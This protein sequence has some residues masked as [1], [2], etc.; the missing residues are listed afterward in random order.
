[1]SDYEN[2]APDGETQHHEPWN[3][4][5]KI[6]RAALGSLA[7]LVVLAGQ[8]AFSVYPDNWSWGLALS[9][10]G[11][12]FFM[13]ARFGRQFAWG[14]RLVGKTPLS[15]SGL[16]VVIAAVFSIM[17]IWVDLALEETPRSNFAPVVVLWAA[18]GMALLAS[19]SQGR[20]WFGGGREWLRHNRRE[21]VLVALITF[22][23]AVVRFYQ[24]GEIPRVINGDEGII[25]QAAL[26]SSQKPLANP[27]SMWE[28]I[29]G[30]FLQGIAFSMRIFGRNPFGLRLLPAIGGTLAIP[31]IYILGRRLFGPRVAFL[32]AV[33]LAFSHSHIHFSR[34]V[35]VSY[36]QGTL[37]EPLMLYFLFSGLEERSSLRM[38]LAA[39]LLSIHFSIYVDSVIFLVLAFIFML[40][41]WFV[42]PPL[43]K[44]RSRQVI[45]F[46]VAAAIMLLP[47]A[48]Y[49]LTHMQEFMG[50]FNAD[51]VI[52]SGWL[53]DTMA[54][55]GQSAVVILAQRIVHAFLSMSYYAAGDFYGATIPLL[56][57]V[58]GAFFLIG[59][60]YSL[61]R[62]REPR[63]LLLNGYMWAPAVA[64]GLTAIPPEADSYRMLIALPAAILLAAVGLEELLGVLSLSNSVGWKARAA[65]AGLI[66]VSAAILNLKSYFVDFAL[67]CRYGGDSVTRFASYL[68]NYL[69]QLDPSAEVFLLNDN[70]Y[71]Y[72]THGSVDFLSGGLQVNNMSDQAEELVAGPGMVVV[73]VPT[74]IQELREWAKMNPGGELELQYD[75]SQ[76]MLMGYRLP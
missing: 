47:Q 44:G 36:T 64:I 16:L 8:L 22:L 61:W 3:D 29:G 32:A 63:Y 2:P 59:L 51:G 67:R 4:P 45:A 55:T 43:M 25:G 23:G 40:V 10:L 39:I 71:R 7:V 57:V 74:R 48:F 11:L 24:L 38:G 42:S 76:L 54:T 9:I 53:A 65:I 13:W 60:V 6:G 12:A 15:L 58:T 35:A 31:S 73:A 21:V 62:T 14:S 17:A 5:A 30:M 33:F 72:G 34:T 46:T 26:S 56:S 49:A 27:L 50:R 75:C 66:L 1:M 69:G 28:S 18:A 41:A 68:G 20:D 52:Q 19:F 37:I 70:D